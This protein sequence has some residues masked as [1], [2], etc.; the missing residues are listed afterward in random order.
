MML[1]ATSASLFVAATATL[2]AAPAAVAAPLTGPLSVGQAD[3]A[4]VVQV[5]QTRQPRRAD[6]ARRTY[7]DYSSDYRYGSPY[8]YDSYGSPYGAYGSYDY[9]AGSPYGYGSG[10]GTPY[11]AF[12]AQDCVHGTPSETSAYPSWMVCNRR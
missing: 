6:R 8:G 11:G 3:A 10:Y 4:L 7:R 2:L 5:Q 1:P 9:G 12:G